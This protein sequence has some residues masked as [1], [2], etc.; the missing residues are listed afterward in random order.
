MLIFLYYKICLGNLLAYLSMVDMKT[1][2]LLN[3]RN[4]YLEFC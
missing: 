2:I 4:Q 1:E 3:D